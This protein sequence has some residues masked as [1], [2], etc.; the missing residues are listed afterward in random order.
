MTKTNP[1]AACMRASTVFAIVRP[2]QSNLLTSTVR[3]IVRKLTRLLQTVVRQD[4]EGVQT[5]HFSRLALAFIP[6]AGHRLTQRST[7]E[8]CQP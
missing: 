8:F 2:I 1:C 6:R 5:E 7:L 3:K 4:I